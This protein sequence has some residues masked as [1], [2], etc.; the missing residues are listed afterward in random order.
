MVFSIFWFTV[1][2]S[3]K[4]NFELPMWGHSHG[5]VSI[6]SGVLTERLN[7]LINKSP[8]K[9][10][11]YVIEIPKYSFFSL[12]EIWI[13]WILCVPRRRNVGI[14]AEKG[15]RLLRIHSYLTGLVDCNLYL[16][17]KHC[18]GGSF[19]WCVFTYECFTYQ[20][21]RLF[22]QDKDHA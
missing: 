1:N 7:E 3:T 14:K 9:S 12:V 22:C 4:A 19:V 8:Q 6:N 13:S 10:I 15:H 20:G 16:N 18:S 17:R 2:L 21:G 5:I 11:L